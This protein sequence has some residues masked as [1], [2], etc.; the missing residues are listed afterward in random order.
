MFGGK[1][2]SK[3]RGLSPTDLEYLSS[4]TATSDKQQLR[5]QFDNFVRKHPTGYITKKDFRTIMKTCFPTHVRA[6][7]A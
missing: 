7:F 2:S 4:V 3:P 5:R 6:S 1:Q